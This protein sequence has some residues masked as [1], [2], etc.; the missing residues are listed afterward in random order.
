MSHERGRCVEVSVPLT[1]RNSLT[2]LQLHREGSS[3]SVE[4][5]QAG[6]RSNLPT[7]PRQPSAGSTASIRNTPTPQSAAGDFGLSSGV[8]LSSLLLFIPPDTTVIF[9]V[10]CPRPVLDLQLLVR[11]WKYESLWL[12]VWLSVSLSLCLRLSLCFAPSLCDFPPPHA[13]CGFDTPLLTPT[14]THSHSLSLPPDPPVSPALRDGRVPRA[15]R[16]SGAE[17]R[18]GGGG[19]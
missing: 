8:L 16:G 15:E 6:S 4:G 18:G 2:L 9:S 1:P 14:A 10:P 5:S 13:M 19:G 7:L 12:S 3:T 17:R 11:V